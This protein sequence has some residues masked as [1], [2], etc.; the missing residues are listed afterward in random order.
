MANVDPELLAMREEYQ[1]FGKPLGNWIKNNKD[2]LRKKI[3]KVKNPKEEK[4]R[5]RP[6]T[7]I[8]ARNPRPAPE[9]A[10]AWRVVSPQMQ[11]FEV[12]RKGRLK[13]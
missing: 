11:L 4:P 13:F 5:G 2:L 8:K 3:E 9:P 12:S 10:H 6:K 1:D 7:K